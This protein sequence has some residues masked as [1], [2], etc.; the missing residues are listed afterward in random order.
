MKSAGVDGQAAD[1]LDRGRASVLYRRGLGGGQP[2][3]SEG[4]A[5]HFVKN[6]RTSPC[7]QT[8]TNENLANTP[9][10]ALC[11]WP[12]RQLASL[13]FIHAHNSVPSSAS[14]SFTSSSVFTSMMLVGTVTLSFNY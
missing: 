8:Q 10:D 5:A 2:P 9:F 7:L 1:G 11:D 3:T 13:D 4:G 12:S 6:A 14:G